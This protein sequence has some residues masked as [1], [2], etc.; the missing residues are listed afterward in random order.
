MQ[1]LT[2][3]GS[4]RAVQTR[5]EFVE[6]VYQGQMQA[7]PLV[8]RPSGE[9]LAATYEQ[10]YRRNPWV[11]TCVQ[12]IA[13]GLFPLPCNV[14]SLNADASRTQIRGDL[15]NT[16]GR[17]SDGQRLARLLTTPWPR[18]SRQL[19]WRRT[20]KDRVIRGNA[21]WEKVRDPATGKI[22]GLRYW[23]WRSVVPVRQGAVGYG[24]I[25]YGQEG[26]ILHYNVTEPSTLTMRALMPS[27]VV[28]FRGGDSEDGELG[29]SPLEPIASELAIQDAVNRQL[30][31]WFGN[32]AN[33]SLIARV[34]KRPTKD[35]E[36]Y[37]QEQF[38]QG[39]G[40]PENTGKVIFSSVDVQPLKTSD[41]NTPHAVD[42]STVSREAVFG[43]FGV[44]PALAGSMAKSMPHAALKELRSWWLRDLIGP[45][46]DD[47]EGELSSQLINDP[48]EPNWS[49]Q[50]LFAE[51][52]FT[53]RLQ[54]DLS[55]IAVALQRLTTSGIWSP[56]EGSDYMNMP[57]S[58]DPDA[59][60]RWMPVNAAPIGN[61]PVA[62]KT[63]G[64]PTP[65][66]E[67][68]GTGA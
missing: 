31:G 65:G 41:S 16:P 5:A 67:S 10:L 35:E 21:L 20:V 47:I 30:K 53:K 42:V 1:L 52:D 40:G 68:S 66:P 32:G 54:P 43:V 11:Y 33:P 56:N 9:L 7:I 38:R 62:N 63:K 49:G 12:I 37:L 36:T 64:L 61:H 26:P 59:D 17:Y 13:R 44:P 3:D 15:P 8:P 27:D 57:R 6:G 29:I 22:T 55:D 60:K 45:F 18:V 34:N 25:W 46:T 19:M 39:Y 2:A 14:Y 28:H 23:P 24:G 51:F 58:T 4:F 48:S 50:C